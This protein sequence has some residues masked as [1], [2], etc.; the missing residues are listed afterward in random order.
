MHVGRT[1]DGESLYLWQSFARAWGTER[2]EVCDER[3]GSAWW[4]VQEW[5][6]DGETREGSMGAED[7]VCEWSKEEWKD[8]IER[9]RKVAFFSSSIVVRRR[10]Y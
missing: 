4:M 6:E 7:W 9:E 8:R 3:W 10:N 2:E 1:A 5:F